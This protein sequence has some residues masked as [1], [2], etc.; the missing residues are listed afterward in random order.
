MRNAKHYICTPLSVTDKEAF[1]DASR[2][3]LRVLIALVECNGRNVST[4][5]L[6]SMA[7]T[8]KA[9][10]ASSLVFWSEAGVIRETESSD[11]PTITEEFEERL[12]KG[13]IR[14]ED[15][16]AVAKSIRS[17]ALADM[18]SECAQLMNRAVLN[19]AEIK[20]LTALHEQYALSEEFIL[21]LAAHLAEASKLTVAKLINRA[22]ALTEKE[23]DTVTAL[24]EYIKMRES[25]SEAERAFRKLFGI[26]NRAAS[27]TEKEYFRKWSHDYGY[28]TEIVGE[29]YDIAVS[30]AT[31]GH[32]SYVDKLLTRWY[33]SGC[34]T[35]AE[36]RAR[37]ESDEAERKNKKDKERKT[38]KKSPEKEKPRYGDFDA[39]AAFLKALERSYGKK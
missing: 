31:R 39:E 29:A 30:N 22:I 28:F 21:T 12:I 20:Q 14:E 6:A 2:E 11:S 5:A 33:E 16:K 38:A 9:R 3:E 1:S 10:A 27:K 36:C 26:Y 19:T 34:R 18:I 13:E 23:I 8:S 32:A 35:V 25:D 7:K 4:E 24:E 15:S 17:S 37:Y